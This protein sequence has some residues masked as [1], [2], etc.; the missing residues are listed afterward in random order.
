MLVIDG[1]GWSVGDCWFLDD[2]LVIVLVGGCLAIVG[3]NGVGKFS[4]FRCCLG[5]IIL[6]DGIV[7]V[8]GKFIVTLGV[9]DWV[10]HLV[11]LF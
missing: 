9:R 11:W 5:W 8:D 7:W 4:L 10:K 6:I 2:F 1:L 3:F